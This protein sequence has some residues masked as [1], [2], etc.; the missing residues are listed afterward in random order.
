MNNAVKLKGEK[1]HELSSGE[2]KILDYITQGY[3]NKEI[4][5]FMSIREQTVKNHVSKIFLKLGARNR[6]Q[7]AIIALSSSDKNR[8]H[9]TQPAQEVGR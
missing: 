9:T 3:L 2:S 6:T 8:L 1:Q 7:A 5:V 4:A